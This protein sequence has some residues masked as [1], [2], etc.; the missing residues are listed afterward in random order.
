MASEVRDPADTPQQAL[1]RFRLSYTVHQ[2]IAELAPEYR[3]VLVLRDL[4]GMAGSEVCEALGIGEAAMKSRLHRAR[5]Q[6]RDFLIANHHLD[7]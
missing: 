6:V 5:R 1:E 7:P 2:A 3:E 4:E